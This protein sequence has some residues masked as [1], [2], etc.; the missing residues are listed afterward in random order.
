MVKAPLIAFDPSDRAL[1]FSGAFGALAA[2]GIPSDPL[3]RT[4]KP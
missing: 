2:G 1:P 4:L 3:V